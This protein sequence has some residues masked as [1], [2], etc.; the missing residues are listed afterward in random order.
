MA[1]QIQTPPTQDAPSTEGM[2]SK[3]NPDLFKLKEKIL[4]LRTKIKDAGRAGKRNIQ[5]DWYRNIL[6]LIGRQWITFDRQKKR[7][8]DS[9]LPQWY[10]KPVTNKFASCHN[11]IKTVLTQKAPRIICKP[12]SEKNDENTATAEVADIIVDVTDEEANMKLFREI[13]SSWLV[14]TGNVFAHNYYEVDG[15]KYGSSFVPFEQCLNCGTQHPPDEIQGQSCP[16]CN[17]PAGFTQA[18]DPNG[19]VMGADIPFGK[20]HTDA[21]PPFEMFFNQENEHWGQIQEC[22]RSKRVAIEELKERYSEIADKITGAPVGEH[23]EESILKAL[24]YATN[25]GF[26]DVYFGMGAGEKILAD[27]V[28]Y[29]FALPRKDF[30]NGMM[31]TIVADNIVELEELMPF[32][33]KLKEDGSRE[34]F[35]PFCFGGANRV[36]GRF[37]HRTFLDDVADKQIQRNKLES[38]ILLAVYSMSGGKWL[39]PEGTNMTPPDGQPNQRLKY[40]RGPLGEEPKMIPGIPPHAVLVQL[41]DKMDKDIEELSASYDVLKGNF[42]PGLDTFSGLRLLT[43]R[44]FSR[45]NEL[46]QNWERFNEEI[47]RQQIEIARIHFTNERKKTL[48]ND[49]GAWETK[50]FSKEDLQG[51]MEITIEEGSTI[52]KSQAVENAGIIDSIKLQIINIHDPKV[53][54]EVLEKLGQSDLAASVGEDIKDAASEWHQFLENGQVRPRQGIDNEA[55]HLQDAI[56]R[57][58]SDEFFKLLPPAQQAW[59]AHVEYHQNNLNAQMM[60]PPMPGAPGPK[61]GVPGAPPSISAMPPGQPAMPSVSAPTGS[62]PG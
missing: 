14:S 55:I 58:K 16:D 22:V 39:E 61:M 23:L 10:E 40:T 13:A 17:S 24:A 44:A 18:M 32:Y 19:A 33:S 54:F 47:K 59:I 57:A 35:L 25:S 42:P 53:N 1:D 21:V 3:I 41:I 50:T 62:G 7:W 26:P 48:E 11:T 27:T 56:S 28:D 52:P 34:A 31:A 6:F 49:L 36:S 60:P 45:H 37:W 29:V 51:G 8:V 15:K 43:E 4:E 30:P 9:P 2:S 5:K 38:F 46:I 12:T 20:L